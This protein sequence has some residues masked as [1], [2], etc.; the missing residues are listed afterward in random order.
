MGLSFRLTPCDKDRRGE[1]KSKKVRGE[2]RKRRL[3][4]KGRER[5]CKERKNKGKKIE[6][7]RWDGEEVN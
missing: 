5:N 6:K 1:K 4:Y 7:F 2:E 3:C